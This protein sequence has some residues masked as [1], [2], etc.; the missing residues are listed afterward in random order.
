MF[1][2]SFN[3]P[4]HKTT[5]EVLLYVYFVGAPVFVITCKINLQEEFISPNS[6]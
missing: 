6:K 1:S 2:V 3:A 4:R 5:E